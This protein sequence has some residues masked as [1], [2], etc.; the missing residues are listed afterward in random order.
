MMAPTTASQIRQGFYD[1][2]IGT[3]VHRRDD[4]VAYAGFMGL[5]KCWASSIARLVRAKFTQVEATQLFPKHEDVGRR[6]ETR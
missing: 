6:L 4:E 5:S 2:K 1:E 3:L